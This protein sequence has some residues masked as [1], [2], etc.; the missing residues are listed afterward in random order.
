MPHKIPGAELHLNLRFH[1]PKSRNSHI[2][3]GGAYTII[4]PPAGSNYIDPVGVSG[5]YVVGNCSSGGFLLSGTALTTLTSTA[6]QLQM[7]GV[8]GNYAVG[9]VTAGFDI[10]YNIS[11]TNSTTLSGPP[12]T[13]LSSIGGIS[14]GTVF[15]SYS[16][17]QNGVG[18]TDGFLYNTSTSAYTTIA[19]PGASQT[20]VTG[21]DGNLVVGYY[22][23]G[24]GQFGFEYTTAPGSWA[25]AASGS[26]SD[27]TKWSGGV[28]AG[29]GATAII[30]VSTTAAVTVTL[31]VPVTLGTLV[32]GSGTPGVGYTLVKSGNTTL[33]F[34]NTSNN[35]AA[36]IS[37]TDGTHYIDAPVILAS[38]LVVTSTSSTPW[39]LTFGPQSNIT[40]NGNHLSLTMNASNGT[41]ILG[42][43][44]GYTGTTAIDNGILSLANSAALAGNGAISF[45]GGTLQFSAS[46]MVDYS[47][48][49]LNS[50]GAISLDTNGRSV[51]LSSALSSTN[52]GGLSKVGSGTLTLSASNGYTGTTLVSG[53]TL[54]L[55]N[56]AA[57]RMSTFDTS[58]TGTLSF[59]TL[60]SATF[61]GLQGFGNLTLENAPK[62]ALS[63][64]VGADNASTTF[65]GDL[66]GN[67]SL[68]KLGAGTLILSGSDSYSGGTDVMAG[69][70]EVT[71][72]DA[73]LEGSSLT[74]GAN[75]SS[76]FDDSSPQTA[77][78][79]PEPSTL[80]LLAV[81]GIIAAAAGS[82]PRAN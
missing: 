34:S 36:T 73:L 22:V 39:T 5:N 30:N 46:N 33:T 59:G 52:T 57:F 17:S 26:W 23:K 10:L 20:Q 27:Y 1:T 25:S 60:T 56:S 66:S 55:A 24:S 67:G 81:T 76:I 32:L 4:N 43:S 48:R 41:L 70:L 71:N 68:T 38:N 12:G 42:C 65:S 29:D 82:R 54:L 64:S 53:G 47:S 9:S 40:D 31:D 77:A 63:L 13:T 3:N 6:G 72:S 78:T 74:V 16:F 21:V 50:S 2:E 28:P 49:I 7:L 35:A 45:G 80:L 51:T 37:V 14:G 69:T 62:K 11:L 15:G 58:G 75:A 18:M 44:D 79:V 8:S 19:V 61:G